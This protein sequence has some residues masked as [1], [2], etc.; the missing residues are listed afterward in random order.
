MVWRD[1]KLYSLVSVRGDDNVGTIAVAL[2]YVSCN[3]ANNMM[4]AQFHYEVTM[5]FKE[6][7]VTSHGTQ[8]IRR[9]LSSKTSEEKEK[10]YGTHFC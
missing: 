4:L 3:V 1:Y 7:S 2:V 8:S 9:N 10:R 5:A 6:C